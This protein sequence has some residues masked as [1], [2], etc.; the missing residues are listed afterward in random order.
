M[1]KIKTPQHIQ[2]EFRGDRAEISQNEYELS[3]DEWYDRRTDAFA[4]LRKF[5]FIPTELLD[6]VEN[7]KEQTIVKPFVYRPTDKVELRFG[8]KVLPKQGMDGRTNRFA[9]MR[10]IVRRMEE[11]KKDNQDGMTS[12]EALAFFLRI[13]LRELKEAE[14]SRKAAPVRT[15]SLLPRSLIAEVAMDLLGSCEAW[16]YPPS[17]FLNNLIREL[18]NLERDRTRMSRD[19][20]AQQRAA[21][22]LAQA[23]TIGTRELARAVHVNASTVS[24]WRRSPEFKQMVQDK[25]KSF[26]ESNRLKSLI[27]TELTRAEKVLLLRAARVV[28]PKAKPK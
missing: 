16:S 4:Q 24:R 7:F 26:K 17:Y 13:L 28:Y 9:E 22:I 15:L 2:I 3:A 6:L 14:R 18:L 10:E 11:N 5:G 1:P 8:V 20:E 25:A 21:A 23:T 19:A 12:S 27:S